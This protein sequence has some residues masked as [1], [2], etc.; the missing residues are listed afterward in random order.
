[1]YCLFCLLVSGRVA[2]KNPFSSR[3]EARAGSLAANKR[4]KGLARATPRVNTLLHAWVTPATVRA[5]AHGELYSLQGDHGNPMMGACQCFMIYSPALNQWRGGPLCPD[6][7]VMSAVV[8]CND[9]IYVIGGQTTSM[10]GQELSTCFRYDP[11][12]VT[13][14][15]WERIPS[16][17]ADGA[18]TPEGVDYEAGRPQFCH[19]MGKVAV[20]N[21]IYIFGGQVD[22]GPGTDRVLALDTDTLA[23]RWCERMPAPR[24]YPECHARGTDVYVFGGCGN[25]YQDTKETTWKYDTVTDTW[26]TLADAPEPHNH[27]FVEN[28]EYFSAFGHVAN[29]GPISYH[30]PTDTWV[31]G[32]PGF[33]VLQQ[34]H[35]NGC[36]FALAMLP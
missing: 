5:L 18:G 12:R 6:G 29:E 33:P 34:G 27:V 24:V 2:P 17:P 15:G 10:C 14:G 36:G 31:E 20:G 32:A 8:A 30:V 35:A 1:M 21:T 16:M 25:C 13:S 3:H 28:G 9:K 19:T 7:R 11:E 26:T 4:A 23:W 22:D